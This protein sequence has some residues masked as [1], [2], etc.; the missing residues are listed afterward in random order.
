MAIA[1]T[2]LLLT[3]SIRTVKRLTRKRWIILNEDRRN[4]W[5]TIVWLLAESC[6]R[7]TRLIIT[8]VVVLESTLSISLGGTGTIPRCRISSLLPRCILPP[9]VL[10]FVEIREK[11]VDSRSGTRPLDV[12][13]KVEVDAV[14]DDV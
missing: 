1:G 8:S 9:F 11:G 14:I 6:T 10:V 7:L 4:W 13:A 5:A 2:L 12:S 3:V